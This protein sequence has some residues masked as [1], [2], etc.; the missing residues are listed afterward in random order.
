MN[1]SI[2]PAAEVAYQLGFDIR[3]LR[4]F[5]FAL[6]YVLRV[7]AHGTTGHNQ[8]MII[9][10]CAIDRGLGLDDQAALTFQGKRVV[11]DQANQAKGQ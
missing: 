3:Q 6:F 8:L 7:G 5:W 4:E 2:L 9:A 1:G 11:F 10:K